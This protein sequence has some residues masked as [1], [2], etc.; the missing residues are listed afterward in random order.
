MF[1]NKDMKHAFVKKHALYLLVLYKKHAATD[2]HCQEVRIFKKNVEHHFEAF[3]N[4]T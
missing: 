2:I 4:D 3:E 1:L